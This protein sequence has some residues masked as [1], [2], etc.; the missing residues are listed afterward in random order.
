MYNRLNFVCFLYKS[1]WDG[2]FTGATMVNGYP[3]DGSFM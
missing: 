2:K 3:K 1:F